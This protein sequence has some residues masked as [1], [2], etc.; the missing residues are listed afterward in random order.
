M[1]PPPP[2]KKADTRMVFFTMGCSSASLVASEIA[3]RAVPVV[4][5]DR[6]NTKMAAVSE[7]TMQ[8]STELC[9]DYN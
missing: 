9:F 7:P 5:Y 3:A 2:K 4:L 8:I 1:W 6:H